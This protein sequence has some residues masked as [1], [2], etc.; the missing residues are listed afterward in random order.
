MVHF[1]QKFNKFM[2]FGRKLVGSGVNMGRKLL[3]HASTISTLADLGAQGLH[4]IGG[5]QGYNFDRSVGRLNNLSTF[6]GDV[7]DVANSMTPHIA[8]A[9][10]ANF[11]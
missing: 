3:N 1:G 6:A 2:N 11:L 8:N 10:S 9:T 4:H 7:H 5:N